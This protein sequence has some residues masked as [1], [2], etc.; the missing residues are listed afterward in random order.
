MCACVSLVYVRKAWKRKLKVPHSVDANTQEFLWNVSN[1]KHFDMT[2]DT[3]TSLQY[4]I[5][6]FR[7]FTKPQTSKKWW[8]TGESIMS[9][10]NGDI[11][12]QILG[13][14]FLSAYRLSVINFYF[15]KFTSQKSRLKNERCF[16]CYT[17][18]GKET[19]TELF[20][21]TVSFSVEVTVANDTLLKFFCN[22]N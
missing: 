19:D 1:Y 3:I 12:K 14:A 15:A 18:P 2:D 22:Q 20:R 6:N 8:W 21:R 10:N 17:I 9:A 13:A 5:P 4:Q 16:D 7:R 11:P